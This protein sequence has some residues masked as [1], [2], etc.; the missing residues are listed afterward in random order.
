MPALFAPRGDD[1]AFT[2]LAQLGAGPDGVAVLARRGARLVE[3]HQLTFGPSSPRWAGLEQRI[4]AI[5]A[6]DHPAIRP[7]LALEPAPPVCVLEG[8]SFPPLAELIEQ[9][10]VDFVR[11]LRILLELGRALSA[12][13][14]VGVFHGN[15][16]PWNVWVGG[17]DRPRFELTGLDTRPSAHAWALRCRS[18]DAAEGQ[19]DGAA[20]VY[21]LGMLLELFAT[22][23]GRG[24]DPRIETLIREATAP[25]PDARP[26]MAELVKRMHAA[27]SGR[28]GRPT[29]QDDAEPGPM[30][31]SVG[32]VIGRFELVRQLGA[33]AMGEVWE[34]RDTAGG[35]NV[36][37]KLLRPEIAADAELLRRFRKEARVLAKVGSPYIA[38]YIDLNEDRGVHYLVLELVVGGS[39]GAALRRMRKLPERLSLEIIADTCRALAEPHR[40]GIVHRDLKPDNMMFVR[41]GLELEAAPLGQLVKLGDFG[42]ARIAEESAGAHAQEGATRDGAVLGTPEY[43][44]PEQCQ[45]ALVTPA[46]DVYAL[47]CCLF[48]LISGR[49]P[50]PVVDDNPM[51]VLLKQLR[52]PPPRLD[53]VAPD[54]SPTVANLVARCLEKDPRNRPADAAEVL[55]EIE[56]MCD[57][58]A[59]LITAHPAPPVQNEKRIVTY[60]FEW[61]LQA[62]PEAL[63]PFVSNTEKMNRATGLPPVRFEIESVRTDARIP[64]QANTTGHQRIAGIAMKWKEHPYEWIEGS[65]QV[66][67]RVFSGGL[68]RWYISEV[69]LERLAGGGTKL[70]NIIRMEPRGWFARVLSKFEIGVKYR[71]NLEKVYRRIDR[72]LA[73]GPSPDIDPIDPDIV[74]SAAARA[75]IEKASDRLMMAGV[76]P[77]AVESLIAYLGHASDQ[78]VARIRP[79]ELA[80]K[81]GVPE[82]AMI[83]AALH[84]AKLG[85]LGMVWDVICPSCRI[86]SSVVESLAKIE[87]HAR[88]KTCNIGFD[89]DFSRAIELAFRAAPDIRDVETQTFCIGGPAHFP[90]VVAQVRLA[91]GERF[92]LAL[93]LTPGYYVLRS[94]QLTRSYEVRVTAQGGVRR[95][96]LTLGVPSEI[97]TMTAGDQLITVHNPEQREVVIRVE[98]AGDRVF[99]LTAA[100]VMANAVFRDL[101]PDQ[102]LAPGRLMAVTQATLV[103][104]QVDDAQTLFRDLGD[105]RAFP[106]ASRFFEIVGSLAREYG[107]TLVKTFGGL[108][109]AGFERPGPGV[110]AALALQAA[111]DGD[112]VTTGLRCRISVHRGPMMA[113]TQAGRLDYFG[114]NV[115]LA[116]SLSAATPPAVVAVTQAVCQDTAV[117][118]RLHTTPD[119]L[120]M[121]P[122]PGGSWVLQISARRSTARALPAVVESGAKTIVQ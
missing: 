25:D 56:Q 109:I 65:R 78:D 13:H 121:Q 67:L 41:A 107:G 66:V 97:V 89:V 57:G 9:S 27:A 43:M 106:V 4:R 61:E 24:A 31:P 122:L 12:A 94:P 18:I 120:G 84:A 1:D 77:H 39:V 119:Q 88:C 74:L 113:L 63:W 80:A 30:R 117:A 54:A 38:N 116:L 79:L 62:S 33:G 92:A 20:D 22:T 86:P 93:S 11:A 103:V 47:G 8:D 70:R 112:P 114:Q 60:T 118:E 82:E 6:I 59:A 102:S 69:Q 44:A 108:A 5:G 73:A 99:A 49:P 17:S 104:A 3:L 34:A 68:L 72:V 35:A 64:T 21:S 52:E 96:D 45:G 29:A 101:F 36:A 76:E 51:A 37:L 19:L 10:S 111:V 2:P 40:L 90:H 110:E 26:Q 98:R 16:H 32:A 91:P 58:V 75:R 55:T 46:T 23:A 105:S 81:F 50:F 15:L 28:M 71:R 14:H 53:A 95:C 42:I 115:E 85:V 83:D 100:R 48:T 87:E 7:V